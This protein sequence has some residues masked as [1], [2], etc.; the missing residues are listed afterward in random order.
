[1]TKYN[2]LINNNI[3]LFKDFLI[4]SI[5]YLIKNYIL[6]YFLLK[7]ITYFKLKFNIFIKTKLGYI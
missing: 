7:N 1:M 2:I 6:Y 3:I 5:R 4:N